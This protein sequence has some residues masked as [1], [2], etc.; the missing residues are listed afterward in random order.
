MDLLLIFFIFHCEYCSLDKS[1]NVKIRVDK[2]FVAYV[3]KKLFTNQ[4]KALKQSKK[5]ANKQAKKKKTSRGSKKDFKTNNEDSIE[6]NL[7]DDDVPEI[8]ASL[9]AVDDN[10]ICI[11]TQ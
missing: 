9:L 11:Q 1:A 2:V 8:D 3:K 4:K 10:E 5:I 7:V 6:N